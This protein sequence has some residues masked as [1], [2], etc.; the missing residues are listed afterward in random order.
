M[1]YFKD[2]IELTHD[3]DGRELIIKHGEYAHQAGGS[4]TVQFGDTV[5]FGVSSMGN[6]REGINFLPLMVDYEEKWYA[7]G[8][9]SGSRFIKREARPSENAILTSRM[10]DRPLRPLFPKKMTNDIQIICSVMS[11]DMEYDPA[12]AAIIAASAAT[13]LS[14]M[15]FEGPVGAVRIGLIDD[16][17]IVNPTYEQKDTGDLDLMVAGTETAITMVES[18]ANEV[19]EAKM[20]EALALA[21]KHIVDICKL[22]NDLKKKVNP[23]PV[24]PTLAEVDEEAIAK[25]TAAVDEAKFDSITG[26]EKKEVKEKMHVYED[27]MIAKFAAEIEAE[28][29][30]ERQIKDVMDDIGKK[31]MRK[32]VIEKGI[33]I[34]GRKVDEVREVRCNTGVLPRTH[35]TGLFQRGETQVLSVA[36]LAGPDAAQIVDTMDMDIKKTYMH[37][38]SFPPY[39]VGEVKPM[40]G[41]SRREIGHGMLAERAL[42]AVL[43]D[44]AEFGYTMRVASEILSCNGSSSMGSVCG[45]TL[46][47]MD[48]GVPIKRP[49]SGIAMGLVMD[50]DSGDYKILTDIQGLEDFAGDMDFKVTG[51]TEGITA[52]QMDVKL[53]GLDLKLMEEALTQA[54]TG[55]G[56]ILDQMLAAIPEYRKE[57]SPYAPLLLTMKIDTDDIRR[58]IGK[59]GETIQGIQA[60]TGAEL[61]I[62]DDGTVVITA[63]DQESGAAAQKAVEMITYKPTVGEVFEGTVVKVMDFGAFVELVPGTDGMVHVSKL[64]PHRIENMFDEVK[65][66]DKLKVKLTEIDDKG[67]LNLSA[68]EFYEENKKS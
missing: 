15:P 31:R 4:V 36:T 32:N 52:L 53:K 50:K 28:E 14:G 48:A 41:V 65:E 40:R 12:P 1:S 64:A 49:V 54:L 68:K 20:L 45:S 29:L 13:M 58:V 5:V 38:Y 51:T 44:P 11:A 17:L 10:I 27:E 34:D 23:T 63:P 59:G 19:S 42:M 24:E 7:S 60:D 35:G 62:E 16:K 18:R 39:S 22:Q 47:L 30:S 25:I 37:H 3:L 6:A 21:H 66:G 2:V 46:A 26:Q 61:S 33:R 43:P 55:R 9:I 57:M 56:Y 67:R 8:K